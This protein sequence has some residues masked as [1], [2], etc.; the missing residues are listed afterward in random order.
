ML[1]SRSR[2]FPSLP[3]SL[4]LSFRSVE[5]TRFM[6]SPGRS[7]LRCV[8]RS[9]PRLGQSASPFLLLPQLLVLFRIDCKASTEGSLHSHLYPYGGFHI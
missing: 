5:L 7:T 6:V 2:L 3:P 8:A 4:P 1:P 9:V